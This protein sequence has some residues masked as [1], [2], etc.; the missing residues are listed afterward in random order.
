MLKKRK[1]NRQNTQNTQNNQYIDNMNHKIITHTCIAFALAGG[2]QAATLVTGYVIGGS[3]QLLLANGGAGN[4]LFEDTAATGGGDVTDA[5][6]AAF[7]SV[8][9]TGSWSI[10]DTVTITGV[11]LPLR[12]NTATGSITFDIRQGL[13]G[14]GASAA[15]GLAS[16]GTATASFTAGAGT[17]GYYVN[18][19]T[20]VSFVADANSTTIGIN[21][22]NDGGDM[23]YKI[24]ENVGLTRYNYNNGNLV[25][26]V[27]TD[28]MRFSV[29]G[30]VVPVPEP[31]STALLGLGGLFLILRRRC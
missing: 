27:S 25:G 6:T 26:S 9:L 23:S 1:H 18:F 5:G 19:D 3:S 4:V 10:G 8:L 11:A 17:S 29:A 31:S 16:L 12:T 21:F 22:A 28:S 2:L 15:G 7:H 24:N 13:G 20:A 14:T 30:S